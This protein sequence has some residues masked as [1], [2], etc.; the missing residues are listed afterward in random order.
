MIAIGELERN[1]EEVDVAY[2]K[3]LP[4]GSKENHQSPQSGLVDGQLRLE[5]R[6]SRIQVRRSVTA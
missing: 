1:A 3:V 4:G 5:P 6:I 2:W